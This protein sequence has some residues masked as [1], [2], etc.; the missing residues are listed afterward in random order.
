MTVSATKHANAAG[1]VALCCFTCWAGGLAG[2]V[3]VDL[4]PDFLNAKNRIVDRTGV[5]DVYDPAADALVESKISALLEGGLTVSEAIQI[6]MLNNRDFQ[7]RFREI[8]VSRADVVQSALLSNPTIALGFNLPEGGGI[9]DFTLGAAQQIADLWQIP[10]RKQIAEKQLEQTILAVGRAGVELAAKVRT[11]CYDV[12]ALEAAAHFAE[13][14]VRLSEQIVEVATHQFEAGQVSDFD[15]NLTRSTYQN[16]LAES[17]ATHGALET[18]RARLGETLGINRRA[19]DWRLV[20]SLPEKSAAPASDGALRNLAY[21]Q[22]MDAMVALFNLEAAEDEVLLQYR[23]VF[24]DVQLG[25]AFERN[26][27]R[28]LPSRKILSDT[29]QASVAA[30]SLT[31][32]S[33]E[34]RGQRR[35]L[36]SQFIDAKLGPALSLTLPIWDQNQA[37]IAKAKQRLGQAQSDFSKTLDRIA[38]D[39]DQAAIKSRIAWELFQ[40]H[41][42]KSIPLAEASVR[43][44]TLLYEAGERD[45]LVLVQS[46]EMLVQRRRELVQAMRDYAVALAELESAVGGRLPEAAQSATTT[47]APVDMV[48]VGVQENGS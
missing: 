28:G 5:T 22:R 23:R 35:L 33:I 10:V 39:V 44:A 13:E 16:V 26:E 40:L 21:D 37:Q 38:L 32:P 24:P 1:V 9:V 17:I 43:G 20:D 4:H 48:D 15:T 19:A 45:V 41:H 12:L 14:N 7:I 6:A 30:G 2:C 29:A 11:Q 25:L 3:S 18:A 27:R 46:Q 36:N 42:D 31:A 34:S 47:T 8:G